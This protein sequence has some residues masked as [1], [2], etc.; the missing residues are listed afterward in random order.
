MTKSQ[1]VVFRLTVLFQKKPALED[2]LR[3]KTI[4]KLRLAVL[5]QWLNIIIDYNQETPV[6]L[7]FIKEMDENER[8]TMLQAMMYKMETPT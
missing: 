3:T 8:I 2:I 5:T 7:S 1:E 6:L 4:K